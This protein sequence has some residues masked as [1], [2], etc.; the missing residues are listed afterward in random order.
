VG[1]HFSLTMR[2]DM[3]FKERGRSTMEEI[4]VYEVKDGKIATERYF[5]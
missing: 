1:N 4:C 3:T 5:Y 2:Y